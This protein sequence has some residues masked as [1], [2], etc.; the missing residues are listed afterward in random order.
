MSAQCADVR[1]RHES[2]RLDRG[3]SESMSA[4]HSVEA[5]GE[6]RGEEHQ[7]TRLCARS[8]AAFYEMKGRTD[9]AEHWKARL[10]E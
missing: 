6:S 7:L 5:S 1:D 2:S 3:R 4:G 8:L 10:D 9:A